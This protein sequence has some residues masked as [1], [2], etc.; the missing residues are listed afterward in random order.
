MMTQAHEQYK[1]KS[2]SRHS[3]SPFV[4]ERNFELQ[5]RPE[6][7][8]IFL[9]RSFHFPFEAAPATVS[10]DSSVS[11]LTSATVWQGINGYTVK[12]SQHFGN[13]GIGHEFTQNPETRKI[14]CSQC[15]VTAL[16]IYCQLTQISENE[17]NDNPVSRK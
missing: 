7:L 17:F 10:Q 1:R 13:L 5:A 3:L 11:L 4:N 14:L 12:F 9:L 2:H 15:S 8:V 6:S 16:A